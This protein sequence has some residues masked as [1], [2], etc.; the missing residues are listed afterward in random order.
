MGVVFL[1][2]F[3]LFDHPLRDNLFILTHCP[4]LMI[5]FK[6]QH[7]TEKREDEKLIMCWLIHIGIYQVVLSLQAE[8]ENLTM[9]EHGLDDQIRLHG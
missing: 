5:L 8:I 3:I 7:G 6:H 1:S 9:E 2:F 4:F